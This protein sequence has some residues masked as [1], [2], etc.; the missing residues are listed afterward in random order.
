M[1]WEIKMVLSVYI[2][3][4]LPKCIQRG[5]SAGIQIESIGQECG[6]PLLITGDIRGSVLQTIRLPRQ[7]PIGLAY[8]CKRVVHPIRAAMFPSH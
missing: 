2:E 3:L 7:V 6:G 5:E 8:Q 4:V 1:G